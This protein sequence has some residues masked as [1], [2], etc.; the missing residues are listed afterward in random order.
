MLLGGVFLQRLLETKRKR[1]VLVCVLVLFSWMAGE[2]IRAFPNYIPYMNQFASA[3]PHW[4]YLSDSNVEWGDD[5]DQL[6][7]YLLDRGETRV[8]AALLGGWLS[9]AKYGVEYVNPL[10]IDQ[11]VEQTRYIAI[12][13]SYLNGSTVP[14]I[15]YEDGRPITEEQRRD[16]FAAYRDRE[17]EAV[18]GNSIYLF[19]ESN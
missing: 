7:E 2:T 9:K 10:T 18:F 1:L 19:R 14:L 17:P 13:A 15:R 5:T 4:Y 11:P 12:G 16:F 8:R 6:A 3:H